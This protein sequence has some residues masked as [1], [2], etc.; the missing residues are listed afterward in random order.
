M[1]LN[2]RPATAAHHAAIWAI[3]EPTIRAGETYALPRDLPRDAALLYWTAHQTFVAEAN[4]EVVGTYYLK[5]NQQGGG[6]HV[7]NCGYM[8]A[9]HATGRGIARAMAEHSLAHAKSNG[10]TAMQFNFV[11]AT[12]TRAIALWHALGFQTLCRL[13]AA[14]HHPTAGLVDALVMFRPL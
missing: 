2:I 3:L 8:T 11:I 10:F 14:Y 7:A 4:N 1:T 5:P 9:P 13:P 12:N 6:A